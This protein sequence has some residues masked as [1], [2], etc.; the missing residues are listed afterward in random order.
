MKIIAS[1]LIIAA[2]F[3]FKANEEKSGSENILQRETVE[4]VTSEKGIIRQLGSSDVYMIE[5]ADKHLKLNA[6]NLPKEYKEADLPVI[7]SGNIKLTMPLE[8]ENGDFFEVS[9][10]H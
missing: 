7:F 6:L 10:I 3:L 2:G 9:S 8:D 4:K 1:I 5:C